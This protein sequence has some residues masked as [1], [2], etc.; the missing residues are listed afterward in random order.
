MERMPLPDDLQRCVDFHGHLCPGVVIG[1]LAARVGMRE[2][3]VARAY[4][5]EMIAIVENDTCAVDAIQLLTGCTFGKGNLIFRD[6]GKMVVSLATRADG[7]SVRL[8]LKP[9]TP[10]DIGDVPEGQRRRRRIEF[11]L[12]VDP[13]SC[14]DMRRDV[15]DELPATATLRDSAACDACGETVMVRRLRFRGD[16]RVCV[17]CD[18]RLSEDAPSL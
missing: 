17:P 2:L 13:A 14:F 9:M 16:R 4:D 3:S 18:E 11:M 1:Y 6:Y 7:R 12:A 5:E 15:L 10:P 8:S